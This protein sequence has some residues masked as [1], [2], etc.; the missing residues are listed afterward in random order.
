MML[1]FNLPCSSKNAVEWTRL[2]VAAWGAEENIKDLGWH[3][4]P[5]SPTVSPAHQK[6]HVQSPAGI[7]VSECVSDCRT[8]VI[9]CIKHCVLVYKYDMEK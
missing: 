2:A 3:S 1:N 4:F 5:T 9:G 6:A 8:T 7:G